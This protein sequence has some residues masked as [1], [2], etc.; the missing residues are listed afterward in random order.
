MSCLFL[1]GFDCMLERSLKESIVV[2]LLLDEL[3]PLKPKRTSMWAALHTN[4]GIECHTIHDFGL[5]GD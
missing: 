2:T 3:N 5:V 4:P 1:F